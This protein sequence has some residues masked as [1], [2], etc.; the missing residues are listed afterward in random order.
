M[1]TTHVLDGGL[2]SFAGAG[3]LRQPLAQVLEGTL[4]SFSGGAL[5]A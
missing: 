3:L 5:L 1:A 4:S 2:A